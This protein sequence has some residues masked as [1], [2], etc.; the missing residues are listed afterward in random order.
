METLVNDF[1]QFEITQ[2]FNPVKFI[3]YDPAD[4]NTIDHYKLD[5]PSTYFVGARNLFR[6]NRILKDGPSYVEWLNSQ[7][8]SDSMVEEDS[9]G[10]D[11]DIGTSRGLNRM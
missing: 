6:R 7:K 8:L 9:E 5:D 10:I 2:T 11:F 4:D 3:T 1:S